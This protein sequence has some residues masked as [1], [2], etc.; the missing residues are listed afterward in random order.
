MMSIGNI[1]GLESDTLSYKKHPSDFDRL[2]LCQDVFYSKMESIHPLSLLSIRNY[3]FGYQNVMKNELRYIPVI[4]F[5]HL[6]K[7]IK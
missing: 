7:N 2:V 4:H 5:F 1:F 6:N 3:E